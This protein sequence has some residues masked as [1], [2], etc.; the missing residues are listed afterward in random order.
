[1]QFLPRFER[2]EEAE[3][4]GRKGEVDVRD[5]I[6]VERISIRFARG[7][8]Y[9][10]FLVRKLQLSSRQTS[11]IYPDSN[12]QRERERETIISIRVGKTTAE[13]TSDG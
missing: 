6:N 3:G 1:M 12:V 9:S 13:L 10:I 7:R 2:Q 8:A 4:W 11:R 5:G